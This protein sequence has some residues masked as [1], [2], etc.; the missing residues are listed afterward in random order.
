MSGPELLRKVIDA[1]G[2]SARKWAE[3]VAWR[4]ERTIR[5]WVAGKSPIPDVVIERLKE[6]AA[7]PGPPAPRAEPSEAVKA[8]RAR[9]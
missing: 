9:Y 8:S 6:I 3:N 5:R 2:L 7:K 4:D 1:S